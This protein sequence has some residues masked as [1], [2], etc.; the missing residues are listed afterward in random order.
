MT[1]EGLWDCV[2]PGH[3]SSSRSM[4]RSS[5]STYGLSGF[6]VILAARRRRGY[7]FMACRCLPL[8]QP[9]NIAPESI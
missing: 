8:G 1:K 2:R 3:S 9:S 5:T 6:A 7:G 4:L